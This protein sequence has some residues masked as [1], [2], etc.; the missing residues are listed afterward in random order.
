M[1][2][3]PSYEVPGSIN[4]Y[5]FCAIQFHSIFILFLSLPDIIHILHITYIAIMKFAVF[6]HIDMNPSLDVF[7]E[8]KR[9]FIIK[10]FT[11]TFVI[12]VAQ[13]IALMRSKI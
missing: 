13:D 10:Y 2:R 1:S 12:A 8:S 6:T 5:S 4:V 3:K 9:I 7:S 11:Q